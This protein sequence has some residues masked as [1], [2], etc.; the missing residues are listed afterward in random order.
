MRA[1]G[2]YVGA[3]HGLRR[4][5][6]P[7]GVLDRMAASPRFRVRHLRSLLAIY[8]AADLAVLGLPWWTYDATERVAAFLAEREAPRVFEFGSGASTLWLADRV[9]HVTAVEHDPPFAE[10]V[11]RL[12]GPRNN[13]TL[14]VVVPVPSADPVTPSQREGHVGL[15]FTDYV[16]SI[17]AA[18]STGTAGET[19]AGGPFD[20]IVVDGRARLACLERATHHLR[21]DGII[22]FDDVLRERYRPA[23]G[24]PGFEAEVLAGAKP[25]LPYRDATALLRRRPAQR[26][27]GNRP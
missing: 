24:T 23:L 13:V 22:V 4:T 17:D 15:D 14:Q 26:H 2:L 9:A 19:D 5:L 12:L 6:Q 20:L 8:D 1:K 27:T 18:G 11:R 10:Q 16:T 25:S 7:T 3:L 21:P